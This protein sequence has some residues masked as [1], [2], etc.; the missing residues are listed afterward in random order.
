MLK[1]WKVEY[2]A[3]SI[4]LASSKLSI[5]SR[6]GKSRIGKGCLSS[7]SISN[8]T[9]PHLSSFTAATKPHFWFFHLCSYNLMFLAYVSGSFTYVHKILCM[10]VWRSYNLMY[11]CMSNLNRSI[12]FIRSGS[13][14]E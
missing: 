10:Y 9:S 5:Y 1:K 14:F 4:K 11:V 2:P 8:G 7:T 12:E 3:N 6:I 13:P